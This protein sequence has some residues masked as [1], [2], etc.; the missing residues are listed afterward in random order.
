MG[1]IQLNRNNEITKEVAELKQ[2]HKSNTSTIAIYR[3]ITDYLYY[4]LP[5]LERLHEIEKKYNE[6]TAIQS[7]IINLDNQLKLIFY[8]NGKHNQQLSQQ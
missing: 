8:D 2:I 7:Q 6:I 4:C 1:V 3:A 5:E